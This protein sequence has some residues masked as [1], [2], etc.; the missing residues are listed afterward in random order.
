[1]RLLGDCNTRPIPSHMGYVL[2]TRILQLPYLYFPVKWSVPMLPRAC[3]SGPLFP[4]A[5]CGGQE[6]LAASVRWERTVCGVA[7]VAPQSLHNPLRQGAA[8]ACPTSASGHDPRSPW[9]AP[10]GGP[11]YPSR[12]P[13][14]PAP[15][16]AAAADF[17]AQKRIAVPLPTSVWPSRAALPLA[18]DRDRRPAGGRPSTA[19]R[20]S[21][22]GR[23]HV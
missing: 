10:A 14:P 22:I 15:V 12:W 16:R 7:P 23:A 5:V 18:R 4:S 8:G 3:R 20:C 19:A 13:Q 11:R 2:K 6:R 21:K 9:A 17:L 1:M